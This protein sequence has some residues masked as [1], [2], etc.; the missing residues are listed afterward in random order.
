MEFN[1]TPIPC[2]SFALVES[3]RRTELS[4]CELMAREAP[5]AGMVLSQ[6]GWKRCEQVISLL[7]VLCLQPGS[8]DTGLKAE[9]RRAF[10]ESPSSLI[11]PTPLPGP[12][13]SI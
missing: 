10:L 13:I 6:E 4:Y 2:C 12:P 7:S 1:K 11:L 8:E 5:Q 9:M 3:E